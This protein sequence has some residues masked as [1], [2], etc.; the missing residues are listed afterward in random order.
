MRGGDA[1]AGVGRDASGCPE[2]GLANEALF[3]A[4]HGTPS[5]GAVRDDV[6]GDLAPSAVAR[7]VSEVARTAVRERRREQR[8]RGH[9]AGDPQGCVPVGGQE[10]NVEER[11]REGEKE[12]TKKQAEVQDDRREEEEEEEQEEQEQEEQEQ[13]QE[14]EKEEEEE[15]DGKEEEEWEEEEE[16]EKEQGEE[17][18][19]QEEQEQEQDGQ[20][21]EE[22]EEEEEDGEEEDEWEEEEEVEEEQEEEEQEQEEQGTQDNNDHV[23]IHQIMKAVAEA[24][25]V[26]DLDMFVAAAEACSSAGDDAGAM[27]FCDQA[28]KLVSQRG[29]HARRA[30]KRRFSEQQR[31]SVVTPERAS[32]QEYR[33]GNAKTGRGPPPAPVRTVA[34]LAATARPGGKEVD[35]KRT[36]LEQETLSIL[37]PSSGKR[38]HRPHDVVDAMGD[39][40]LEQEELSVLDAGSDHIVRGSNEQHAP[41]QDK[42]GGV[43][44]PCL[45][46]PLGGVATRSDPHTKAG[47]GVRTVAELKQELGQLCGAVWRLVGQHQTERAYQLALCMELVRRGVTVEAEAEIPTAQYRGEYVDWRRLDLLLRVADRSMARRGR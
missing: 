30:A 14:E 31:Y 23:R 33:S 46:P 13:E 4:S 10:Q 42:R 29:S 3:N 16:V 20:E 45:G 26:P 37:D 43:L 17:E 8:E 7:G 41:N 36:E 9:R 38:P 32:R 40:L 19:E 12:K 21:Q 18:Q 11:L 6:I 24:G 25:L 5:E 34:R 27:H 47:G 2:V 22:E 44:E 15:E 1:S 35:A 28:D 39:E